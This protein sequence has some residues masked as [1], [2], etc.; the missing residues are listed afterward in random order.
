MRN[1]ARRAY[2][3]R[4]THHRR[5]RRLGAGLAVAG[6]AAAVLLACSKET[7]LRG[8]TVRH[9]VVGPVTDQ[10]I[11]LDENA[12]PK[13]VTYVALKA[14]RDDV[15][16]DGDHEAREA[17]FDR[18]LAVCAPDAIFRHYRRFFGSYPVERDESVHKCVRMWA[19]TL[20][21]Y[22]GNFD[23]DWPTAQQKM[24]QLK[25][26]TSSPDEGQSVTVLLEAA[27]P[28]PNVVGDASV[29][30]RIELVQE[31]GFWRV[32]HVGF[33]PRVRHLGPTTRPA[34]T[35]ATTAPHNTQ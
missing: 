12:T 28:D 7:V 1:L 30:I 22:V 9:V 35:N 19:P 23:F 34:S 14:I 6:A 11:V 24:L 26:R 21:R 33:H 29:V 18:E 2:M 15:L 16:A 10:G 27:D 8:E 4:S 5:I 3:D 17:A 20:D 32:S 25:P 13:Q 31:N